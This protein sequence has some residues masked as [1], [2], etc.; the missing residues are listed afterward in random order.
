M[1]GCGQ[2]ADGP[3]PWHIDLRDT[4]AAQ[5]AGSGI[6][7]ITDLRPLLRARPPSFY[8]HRAC[9]GADGRMVAYL[10]IPG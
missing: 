1:A 6:R 5:A 2:P 7:A 4:L 9:R 3:G 10:G 8:S